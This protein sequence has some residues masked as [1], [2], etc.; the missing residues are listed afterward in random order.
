MGIDQ[1]DMIFDRALLAAGCHAFSLRVVGA[2]GLDRSGLCGSI[3]A[4]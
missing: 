1:P 2:F 3:L 4:R